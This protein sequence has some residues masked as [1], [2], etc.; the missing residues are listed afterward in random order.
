MWMSILRFF[1]R[2]VLHR[3]T[4]KSTENFVSHRTQSRDN[5][6]RSHS[7]VGQRTVVID[8]TRYAEFSSSNLSRSNTFPNEV[9]VVRN[10]IIRDTVK[11]EKSWR[12]PVGRIFAPVNRQYAMKGSRQGRPDQDNTFRLPNIQGNGGRFR[13]ATDSKR[14]MSTCS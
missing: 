13:S 11:I 8:S 5:C 6:P 10:V 1:S 9:T 2:E 7:S 14:Y 12:T 3:Q 4:E